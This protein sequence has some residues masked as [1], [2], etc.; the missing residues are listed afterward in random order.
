MGMVYS[1]LRDE[2]MKM[3]RAHALMLTGERFGRWLVLSRSHSGSRGE[4]YW[5][6]RCDCGKTGIV[7]AGILR[8]GESTSCGCYHRDAVTTHGLS[9]SPTWNSWASM[10]QRCENPNAP[11]YGRYGGRGIKIAAAWHDFENF[12]TD[13]GERQK[14]TSLER[15]D[16]NLGYEP[17]NCRWASPTEQQRNRRDAVTLTMDGVTKNI[18][19]WAEEVGISV[20]TLKSRSGARWDDYRTLTT[21][22]RPKRPKGAS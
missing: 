21:P 7:R 12:V 15:C 6:C 14:G 19:D 5:D 17:S 1:F 20:S 18:H 3:T 22:A 16:V 4:V 9:N 2:E 11:D 13:M 8:R 10:M